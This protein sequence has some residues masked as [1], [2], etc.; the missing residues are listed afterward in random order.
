MIGPTVAGRV[1]SVKV[2]DAVKTGQ[3]IAERD[4][5]DIDQRLAS[6]GAAI[7]RTKSTQAAVSRPSFQEVNSSGCRQQGL[8]PIGR[9]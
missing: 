1:L 3:L 5:V 4:P 6:L 8:W 7:E 9:Q 2:D